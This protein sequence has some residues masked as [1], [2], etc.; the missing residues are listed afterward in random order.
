[1]AQSELL[2]YLIFICYT[3]PVT[4]SLRLA[5]IVLGLFT[6]NLRILNAGLWQD[7]FGEY[8][9]DLCFEW[10]LF[11][12]S[13]N[14]N[15]LQVCQSTRC[16]LQAYYLH[17]ELL[18]RIPLGPYW[19]P[20]GRPCFPYFHSHVR[21][22]THSSQWAEGKYVVCKETVRKSNH[23]QTSGRT[24]SSHSFLCLFRSSSCPHGPTV[25]FICFG[26]QFGGR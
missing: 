24:S 14:S 12:S 5:W 25:Y 10:Y 17:A 15:S 6:L 9:H 16:L 21:Y 23:P 1:M 18:F 8:E 2:I 11:Y 4:L 13:S 19:D 3:S 20:F 22:W 7:Y 26:A